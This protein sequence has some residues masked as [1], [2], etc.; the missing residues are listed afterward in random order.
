MAKSITPISKDINAWYNDVCLRA[1]LADYGAVRGTMVIRPYGF[2]IWKRVQEVLGGAINAAG[3]EDAYFPLFIPESFLKR[4]A[5]HVEGFAPEVAWV[6]EAG[7]EKL[8]ER[9]A[10]RPTSETI[11]YD[12][13][14]RWIQSHRDLPLKINQWANV[15]RWEKR[16]KLFLRTTEFLWQEGHTVHVAPEEA[17]AET[18]RALT[19]YETF[20]RETLAVPV[21]SGRKTES[22]KFAGALYTTAVESL[23][24]DGKALQAGTSHNLG[25]NFA[26]AFKIEY[27]DD[28]GKKAT[29]WQTSWGLSTRIVAA[30][31]LTHGDDQGLVMPPKIA[32]VQVAIVPIF[33]TDEQKN[34]VLAAA[35]TIEQELR[36]RGVRVHLDGREQYS[37][38]YKFNH[39]EVRGVPVRVEIGPKDVA[40][41]QAVA[42]VR[43]TGEKKQL[44]LDGIDA[45]ITQLL[46]TVQVQMLDRATKWRDEH[47]YDVADYASF[48]TKIDQGG[49]FRAGWCGDAKCEADVKAETKATIRVLP[50]DQKGMPESCMKCGKSAKRLAIFARAH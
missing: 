5:E 18:A 10:V 47:T 24:Q 35:T 32:P 7:G 33:K 48:K 20:C 9:V 31:I 38:G 36:K 44:P 1:E 12:T 3:V 19:A 45:A 49:F 46:D 40:A 30:L 2:S 15:V 27:T 4:E 17:E 8:A 42:V 25:Q 6:T 43:H 11:M 13:F 28:G 22:E 50:F 39:W 37:P 23:L 16:T 41:K 29:P 34:E 21:I 26:K 14:S